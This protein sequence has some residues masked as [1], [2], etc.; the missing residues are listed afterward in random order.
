MSDRRFPYVLTAACAAVLA[1]LLALGVCQVQRL[2]W[3]VGLIAQA[4]R[5][6]T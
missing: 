1:M 3:K 4:A 2:M 6:E 5:A